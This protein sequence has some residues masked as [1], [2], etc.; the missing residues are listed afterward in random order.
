M[1]LFKVICFFLL[2]GVGC[3]SSDCKQYKMTMKDGTF[4]YGWDIRAKDGSILV[5]ERQ[6]GIGYLLPS[7]TYVRID[8]IGCYKG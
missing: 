5:T 8:Y 1:K 6:G 4:I 2:I 7:D 3:K